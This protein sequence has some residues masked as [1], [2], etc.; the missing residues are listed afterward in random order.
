MKVHEIAKIL[1]NVV[2]ALLTSVQRLDPLC[3][4]MY[5]VWGRLVCSSVEGNVMVMIFMGVAT[6]TRQENVQLT[7]H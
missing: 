1:S 3:T 7:M 4:R 6:L 5:L 2:C